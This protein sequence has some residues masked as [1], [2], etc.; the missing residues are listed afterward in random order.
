MMSKLVLALKD[1]SDL[2][3]DGVDDLLTVLRCDTQRVRPVTWIP[4]RKYPIVVTLSFQLDPLERRRRSVSGRVPCGVPCGVI[5]GD[6]G[7]GGGGRSVDAIDMMDFDP[8][9]L[10]VGNGQAMVAHLYRHP[11]PRRALLETILHV[12]PVVDQE[13]IRALHELPRHLRVPIVGIYSILIELPPPENCHPRNHHHDHYVPA[14]RKK[15]SSLK[16]KL[17]AGRRVELSTTIA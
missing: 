8:H 7:G 12:A 13:A 3:R 16:D 5:C 1:L 11:P 14:T 4:L 15:T 17:C 6:G 10:D 9:P 2:Q